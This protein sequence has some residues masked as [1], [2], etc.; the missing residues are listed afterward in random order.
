MLCASGTLYACSAAAG[1]CF[2]GATLSCGMAGQD[3]AID[4]FRPTRNAACPLPPSATRLRAGCAAP[5]TGCA[6]PAA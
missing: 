2:E 3:G 1:P 6:G 4:T 5:G